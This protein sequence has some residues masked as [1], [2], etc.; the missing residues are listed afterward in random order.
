[1]K[2]GRSFFSWIVEFDQVIGQMEAQPESLADLALHFGE[3]REAQLFWRTDLRLF[4]AV[5]GEI[6]TSE[7]PYLSNS[8]LAASSACSSML[9]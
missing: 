8:A 7:A 6:A 3:N 1:L 2:V 5:C 4:G 9:Q